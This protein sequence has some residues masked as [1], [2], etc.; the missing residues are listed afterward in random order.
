MK[1]VLIITPNWPPISCPD[2]HRV[3]MSLSFFNEFAWEPLILKINP[4]EQEGI[5]DEALEKSI[6]HGTK[7]WQ[8][9][10]L[11]KSWTRWFGVN[12]VGLRSLFH[13]AQLGRKIIETAKPDL[14]YFS[15]T[16]FMM[17]PLG[18]YWYIKHGIPYI[19]DFQDPWL[20]NYY[21]HLNSAKPPG[22]YFKYWVSQLIAKHLESFTLHN[23]SHII[24]VSPEY[25]KTL[26]QRYPWINEDKCTVLP[27]GAPEKD[28]EQLPTLKIQ[29]RIFNPNDGNRHWVYV[30]RG[31]N[32]MALALKSLFLGIQSARLQNPEPWQSVK[33]HFVGTSYA[34]DNRAVKTVEP[35]AQELGVADLVEE[36]LHRIPYFEALQTLVDSDAILLIGSQDPSYTASKLYPCILAKK[37]IFA[38]FHQQS[39]VVE[40]LNQCHAGR[41]VTFRESDHPN[42]LLPRI[43]PQLQWL[44]SMPKGYQPDT[45]WKAFQP[46]TAKEMT[47]RQCA[48]FDQVLMATSQDKL[49]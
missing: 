37:P 9:G 25:P 13:V 49:L 26:I 21:F 36:H 3:R 32:D 11:Y 31:G 33:L 48:V 10:C 34:S 42:E 4:N 15:T 8:A 27:F 20:S 28:F 18:R 30:G 1:R 40:I 16:M 6:P 46:Y 5:K 23:V 12:S 19:I 39:S 38:I 22:G 17:M 7:I 14:I 45:D 43:I 2:M 41:V 47:R 44:L 24:S 29:Q 35:I